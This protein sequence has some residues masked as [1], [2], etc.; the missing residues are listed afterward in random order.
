MAILA[1]LPQIGQGL[2][3][4]GEG[5]F[6]SGMGGFAARMVWPIFLLI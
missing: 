3:V 2:A 4:G 1:G 6:G 5:D